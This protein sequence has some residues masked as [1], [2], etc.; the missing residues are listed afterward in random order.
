MVGVALRH[1]G[2][3]AVSATARSLSSQPR[4]Y[5]RLESDDL[6][7][8][9][10]PRMTKGRKSRSARTLRSSSSTSAISRLRPQNRAASASSSPKEARPGNG[11]TQIAV[12]SERFR[13]KTDPRE[14][15]GRAQSASQ[16]TCNTL[17]CIQVE[18]LVRPEA[19][20]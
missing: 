15:P 19:D 20:S 18:S 13:I 1:H 7:A 3:D 2:I 10:A 6:P 8:P 4:D 9:D 11:R 14:R 17:V 16:A 12:D 5:P